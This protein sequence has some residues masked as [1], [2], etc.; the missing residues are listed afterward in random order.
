MPA[1]M[2]ELDI[3]YHFHASAQPMTLVELLVSILTI[4]HASSQQFELP[5]YFQEQ[6]TWRDICRS[7]LRHAAPKTCGVVF[8][9][10]CCLGIVLD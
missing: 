4:F 1:N 10:G 3:L 9:L 6:L 8:L 2:H 5:L 7:P